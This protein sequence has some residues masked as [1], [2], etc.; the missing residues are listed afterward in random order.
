MLPS[1]RYTI[2]M[3]GRK[4]HRRRSLAT[5]T[6]FAPNLLKEL[7]S[8]IEPQE[9]TEFPQDNRVSRGENFCKSIKP[10]PAPTYHP[11]Q[12]MEKCHTRS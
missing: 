3:P 10:L 11:W 8:F 4:V 5:A 1:N 12:A 6:A 7:K 9:K 2:A